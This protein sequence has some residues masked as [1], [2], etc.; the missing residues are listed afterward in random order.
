MMPT[1]SSLV[2]PQVVVMTTY[3]ARSNDRVGIIREQCLCYVQLWFFAEIGGSTRHG[4]KLSGVRIRSVYV[5]YSD[6][7]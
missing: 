1:F 6:D 4:Q 7:T 5:H 2:A 3:G